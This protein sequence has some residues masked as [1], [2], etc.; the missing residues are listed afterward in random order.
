MFGMCLKSRSDFF[1]KVSI[2]NS[3]LDFSRQ[4]TPS[5]V[6]NFSYLLVNF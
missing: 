2:A 5:Q 4:Q 6:L 3:N 1:W